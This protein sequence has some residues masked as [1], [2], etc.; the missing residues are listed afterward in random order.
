[1]QGKGHKLFGI[2]FDV[3]EVFFEGVI[4]HLILYSGKITSLSIQFKGDI[5]SSK[6]TWDYFSYGVVRS[7]RTIM[8]PFR[9]QPN[10]T[11][12]CQVSPKK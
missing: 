2:C 4:L 7:N 10:P 1:M 6:N 5:L 12:Q 11:P 3:S 9:N 8:H